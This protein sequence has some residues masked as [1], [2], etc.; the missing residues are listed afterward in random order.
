M[1]VIDLAKFKQE[2]DVIVANRI[3]YDISDVVNK[4]YSRDVFGKD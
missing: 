4:V 2:P 1:V 3:T